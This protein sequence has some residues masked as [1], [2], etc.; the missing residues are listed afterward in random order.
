MTPAAYLARQRGWHENAACLDDGWTAVQGNKA[1]RITFLDLDPAD[2]VA[3][4]QECPVQPACLAHAITTRAV[5]VVQ[6]GISIG[7]LPIHPNTWVEP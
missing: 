3:V 1:A 2:A 4:C 7:S 6:A 5:G